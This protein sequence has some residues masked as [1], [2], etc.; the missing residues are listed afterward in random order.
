MHGI[1]I[2]F[3]FQLLGMALH[4]AGVPLPGTVLG[5]LLFTLSL[6]SGV[7]KVKWVERTSRLLLGNMLL[8]FVPV[9]VATG[10]LLAGLKGELLAILASVVV[11]LL[12]VMLTT[13]LVS[14]HLL[15]DETESSND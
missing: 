9:I 6:F 1:A 11:S 10:G 5:L 15:P 4:A 14:H 3:G 2:L 8:F 12:A 7:I 13:G